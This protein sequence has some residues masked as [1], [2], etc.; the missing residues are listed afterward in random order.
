MAVGALRGHPLVG[1][2]RDLHGALDAP[3]CRTPLPHVASEP[4][5]AGGAS[6]IA[7]IERGN[8]VKTHSLILVLLTFAASGAIVLSGRAHASTALSSGHSSARPVAIVKAG[9][10]RAYDG[11]RQI[12]LRKYQAV[13]SGWKLRCAPGSKLILAFN[14]GSTVIVKPSPTPYRVPDIPARNGPFDSAWDRAG[15]DQAAGVDVYSPQDGGRAWPSHVAFR[16]TP[17]PKGAHL[18]LI[19][20]RWPEPVGGDEPLWVKSITEN[21]S[22]VYIS[23]EA[24]GILSQLRDHDPTTK[25]EFRLVQPRR[26]TTSVVF[27]LISHEDEERLGQELARDGDDDVALMHVRRASAFLHARLY[28]DAA[29]EMEQALSTAPDNT[30]LRRAAMWADRRCGNLARAAHHAMLLSGHGDG[31]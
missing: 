24:R 8:I 11:A 26:A 20:R 14:D 13:Y 2:H 1:L 21:G 22:G 25:I 29:D 23:E 9:D 6:R 28:V 7:E 5:K 3:G 12:K 16:W 30:S 27:S 19:L 15:L 4:A 10:G 18:T 31:L 17:R